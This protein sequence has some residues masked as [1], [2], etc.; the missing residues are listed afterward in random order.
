VLRSLG[1]CGSTTGSR[2]V[3]MRKA[4]VTPAAWQRLESLTR[5]FVQQRNK[6]TVWSVTRSQAGVGLGEG[7]TQ[8]ESALPRGKG[9]V[10]TAKP[11]RA[12]S[13]ESTSE[14]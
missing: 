9:T 11:H 6:E 1:P 10:V 14:S 13:A 12:L 2:A 7:W 5:A 4:G 3:D 8:T